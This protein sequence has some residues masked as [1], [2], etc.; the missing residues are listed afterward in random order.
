MKVRYAANKCIWALGGVPILVVGSV[1]PLCG[2][3]V[4]MVAPLP[5]GVK[6]FVLTNVVA[7]A[8]LEAAKHNR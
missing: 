8:G 5:A 6:H 3:L 2:E 7:I 4:G 1:A